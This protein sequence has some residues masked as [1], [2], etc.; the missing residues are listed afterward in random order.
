MMAQQQ[1]AAKTPPLPPDA[2]VVKDTST[3]ETERKAAK[4][5][6]DAQIAQAKMQ[7]DAKEAQDKLQADMLLAAKDSETK[8][9]IKNAELTHETIRQAVD[10]QSVPP[11][12]PTAPQTPPQLILDSRESQ[13]P[14][15][16][17]TQAAMSSPQHQSAQTC[18]QATPFQESLWD[19]TSLISRQQTR[20]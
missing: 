9:Q 2:Q 18:F 4:D 17:L 5:K 13:T 20:L 12:V 11:A 7:A 15:S 16:R 6:S 10:S 14:F 1:Q 8:I 3:A 19:K